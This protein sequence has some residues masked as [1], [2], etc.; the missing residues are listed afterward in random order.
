L[1]DFLPRSN[2]VV[3][4]SPKEAEKEGGEREREKEEE[5]E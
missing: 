4:D 2:D 1:D 5:K 3:A